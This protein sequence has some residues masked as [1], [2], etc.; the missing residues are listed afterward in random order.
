MGE[1]VNWC[2]IIDIEGA[3]HLLALGPMESG[4][5]LALTW[6]EGDDEDPMMCHAIVDIPAD[7]ASSAGSESKAAR[8]LFDRCSA[9]DV[10]RI[11]AHFA[12]EYSEGLTN[13][14][15]ERA[16]GRG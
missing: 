6:R 2:R 14:I 8:E 16:K 13:E 5:A 9:A 12:M 10:R 7:L 4:Y 11:K 1:E 15:I 3:Q